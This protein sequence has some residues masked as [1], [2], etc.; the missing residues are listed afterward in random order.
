MAGELKLRRGTTQ[1][2]EVFTGAQA[3]VTVDTDTNSLVVHDGATPGGFRVP[4]EEALSAGD[5]AVSGFSGGKY[6]AIASGNT[7]TIL[8]TPVDELTGEPKFHVGRR[9]YCDG[10]AR[11]I[12]EVTTDGGN[13]VVT[14]DGAALSAGSAGVWLGAAVRS[15]LALFLPD[16]RERELG[17]RVRD[18]SQRP[19]TPERYGAVGNGVDDDS[20]AVL[21]ALNYGRCVLSSKTYYCPSL[22]QPEGDVEIDGLRGATLKGDG[23]TNGLRFTGNVSIYNVRFEDYLDGLEDGTTGSIDEFRLRLVSARNCTS[24]IDTGAPHVDAHVKSVTISGGTLESCAAQ[25]VRFTIPFDRARVR[26]LTIDGANNKGL[27]MGN[28]SH[29]NS[30]WRDIGVT[31][32]T[33]KNISGNTSANG[34]LVYGEQVRITHNHVEEVTNT[35]LNDCEGIYTKA[36]Y[37]TISHNTLVNAGWQQAAI[38]IK[39]TARGDTSAPNGYHVICR[40]NNIRFTGRPASAARTSGI[41]AEAENVLIDGN[42]IEGYNYDAIS[43]GSTKS[44]NVT[45][46]RNKLIDGA[47]DAGTV[48]RGVYVSMWSEGLTISHNEILG[49]IG[50]NTAQA[51]NVSN[52]NAATIEDVEI[53]YNKVKGL[54]A[55]TTDG[56]RVSI[57][58]SDLALLDTSYN[59]LLGGL[60]NGIR[61]D[62]SGGAAITDWYDL[63][64][65]IVAEA[66]RSASGVTNTHRRLATAA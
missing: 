31:D 20:A 17:L 29:P 32:C 51:I 27:Q 60:A 57:G 11:T 37:A 30:Q 15:L 14:V 48:I 52:T 19:G 24:L 2:H 63:D 41:A 33:I 66:A 59:K 64:N 28:D 61:I 58:S 43:I 12:T 39:G 62:T 40:S 50:V 45:I 42:I 22:L 55:P 34:L 46:T 36:T 25:G 13:T 53:N 8:G 10:E 49:M 3:E 7:L 56:I 9:V 47:S 35:A 44:A 1:Q 38:A 23:T 16:A 26:D 5:V 54:A 6:E 21:D 65:I 18:Y 4:N